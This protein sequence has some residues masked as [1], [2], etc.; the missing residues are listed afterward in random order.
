M[1]DFLCLFWT[2][3]SSCL[4]TE[5][6]EWDECSASCGTGMKRR[7]RM[8]KMTPADGSMCKAE[9]TEAEKCM[10]PECRKW[11]WVY[12]LLCYRGVIC[13]RLL[14][15]TKTMAKP[16]ATLLFLVPPKITSLRERALNTMFTNRMRVLVKNIQWYTITVWPI[17]WC[18]H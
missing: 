9:T 2:A 14:H 3:P 1:N 13:D 7:H 11:P 16:E 4:V 6:G 17:Q 10:M 18:V 8:I 12:H 15:H 5:W